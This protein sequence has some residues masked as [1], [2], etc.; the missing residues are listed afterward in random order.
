MKLTKTKAYYRMKTCTSILMSIFCNFSIHPRGV[1]GAAT[2]SHYHIVYIIYFLKL[3]TSF[4]SFFFTFIPSW[5]SKY[6]TNTTRLV[7]IPS[8]L[9][10]FF[11]NTTRLVLIPIWNRELRDTHPPPPWVSIL[12]PYPPPCIVW[13]PGFTS[14]KYLK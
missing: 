9:S 4:H 3:F 10:N 12:N 13:L 5:L 11:T 8:W 14:F 6:Y 7:F 1:Y 2:F